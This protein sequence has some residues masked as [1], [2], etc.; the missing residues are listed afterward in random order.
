MS[1]SSPAPRSATLLDLLDRRVTDSPDALL[2]RFLEDEAEPTLSYA[3]LSRHARRIAAALQS[4]ASAGER[5]VLLYPPGLEYIAGFFGCLHAGLVAVPAYPPDPSRLERT[6]P[7]L[8]A[9]IRDAQATVVLTTSFIHSMGDFLFE[10]APDLKDL[11]WVATDA[12]PEDAADSW[13]RPELTADSLAFLQYTSGSTGTPKGVMLTH[14]NLLD[15][16]GHIHRSFGAHDDSVG[17]IWL[18][19]YHDMGLI[20]GILEPLYGGF[21]VA[22]L[23]PL[24]FLK[25]PL[26]WLEAVSRFGG[27]ISGG[28]NFAFELCT[29]KISPEQRQQLDLSRWELAFCGAE[30]IRPETLE[31]FVE[32][33]GPSGFRREALYPCY[34]LAEGTLIV[35]GA[36]KGEGPAL[37]AVKSEP[38]G[39][40]LVEP[41]RAGEQDARVLVGCGETMKEH[42]VLIVEPESLRACEAGQVG[43][44]WV[45]GPSVARGY[46][47][48]PEETARAFHATTADGDGP[49]LRTGD[50]GFLRGAELFVTGRLKDLLILRGR[51][52]YP[53]DLELTAE[54]AHPALRPGCG[55]AFGVEVEGEERLV[56]VQEVDPRRQLTSVDEVLAAVRQGLAESHEVQLHALVL[57]EPGSIPKTSSGKIQRQGTR[58]AWLAG[59]LREVLA[60]RETETAPSSDVP[61]A[62]GEETLDTAEALETWLRRRLAARAGVRLEAVAADEPITRYGLDSLGAA[63]LAHDAERALGVALSMDA[64]LR[65]PT[66]RALARELLE[67]RTGATKSPP[68]LRG[69]DV[70]AAP[71]SFTQQ[72]LWFLQQLEPSSPVYNIPAALR[73]EGALDV[74][75]LRRCFDLLVERHEALRTRVTHVEGQPVQVIAPARAVELPV[76]DLRDLP[77]TRREEE[78]LR[79]ALAQARR[80]FDLET[81]PLMRVVLLRLAEHTHVLALTLHHLVADGTSMGVL[82]RELAALYEALASGRASPLP[83]L[84]VRYVDYARWQRQWLNGE[85]QT[86]QVEYWRQRLA[87]AP[88]ALELP[89][90]K[91][92]PSVSSFH[93]A[94]VPV[95]LSRELT[96]A[97]RSLARDEGGTPFMVLLAGFQALLHRYSGQ[98]DLCVGTAIA[99]RHRAE[100]QGLVGPFINNLVLRT[101]LSGALTFRELIGR[102]REVTLGAYAHQDVPFEKLVEELRPRRDLGRAPFFQVMLLL[103]QDPLPAATMPGLSLRSLDVESPAAKYDLTLS[104]TDTADGLSGTLEYSTD[105]FEAGTVERMVTHLIA[106][107]SSAVAEPGQRV[108]ALGLLSSAEERRVTVEWNATAANFDQRAT[109]TQL[110]SAQAARTPEAV[111]LVCG[112]VSVTYQELRTRASALAHRLRSLG[113]GPGSLV[114]VCAS[115]SVELVTGLLGVLEAGGAYVPLDPSYPAERLA[116]MLRDCGARVLLTQRHLAGN[117]AAGSTQCVFLDEPSTAVAEVSSSG[118]ALPEGLAYVLYTSGST[119]TPKGVMVQH[120]NVA[121]FF[122]G[123]DARLGAAASGTWLAVTSV[124]FDISVLELLWTLCRGF[125]VVV[126]TEAEQGQVAEALLRHGATH[127]QLTPS[128]AQALLTETRG[129]EA[130][131]SVRRLLVGGEA[132][133]PELATRLRGALRGGVLLNMYG[134]TETTIWSSTHTVGDVTGSISIGTPIANTAL[135][136]LDARLRPVPVGVAGELYIGGEGVARGYLDRPALTAE[137]FV[138]DAYSATPG[139]RMYRTGDL[140]RWHADGTVEFLGRVDQQV[141]VRGYRIELGEVE[142]ALAQHPSVSV[143][144]VAARREQQGDT[145]LVAY[146]VPSGANVDFSA[147]RASLRQRLPEYMV[148]SAFMALDA[149]P[150]TPNGKVDR[151]A[152]PALD[153][154]RSEPGTEY[155]A[156]R[157]STEEALARVWSELLGVE[158]VGALDDFFELGGH[159]LLATQVIARVRTLFATELPLRELFEARTVA[160]L[161][162]RIEAARQDRREDRPYAPMRGLPR[163]DTLPLSFAQQR[164][165]VLDR[166]EPDSPLYNMPAVL[167]L[168]GTLDVSALEKTFDAAIRR[169]EG[170][171]ATFHTAQGTTVQRIASD[172]VLALPVVDV[173]TVPQAT[174]EAEV[175]RRILAEVKRPFDLSRAPLMRVLLLKL[176]EQEHVL[177][178]TMHHIISDGWSMDILVREMAALYEAITAGRPSP[179]PELKLQYADFAAW[180]RQWLE[181]EVLQNQLGWWRQ[182][183]DGIPQ[184]LQLPTDKPRPTARTYRGA[185][186][187][188]TLPTQLAASLRELSQREG[189]T[190]YMTLLAAFDVLLSRYSGQTDIVVGTDIANRT[191]AETEG[192]VGFFINQLVMRTRLDGDPTFRELLARVRE[193]SLGAYAHQDVPF[194][195]LVREL[196]PE[197]SL[198]HA[199]LFQ[200]KLVLQNLPQPRLELPGLSME[201]LPVDDHT[202]KFD[203]TVEFT[204]LPHGL[205]FLCEY[206]TD[207]FEAETIERMMGHLRT[208]LESA[209]AAPSQRL[210]QLPMLTPSERQL[211]LVD[212]NSTS[213]Q[214]LDSNAHLLFEAQVART[215][216]APAVSFESS[217]LTYLQLN[218]RSNQL[219]RH[220]RSLGVGPDTLVGLCVERSLDMVV[221]ILAV[222][223]AGGAYL[224]LDPSYP[225]QRLAFMLQ[226]ARPPVLL[227]QSHLADELP[228]QGEMLF[229]LDSDWPQVASLPDGDLSPLALADH[230]AYVIFTSGSTGQPKG[231]LLTH[232]GLC[233][234]ALAA[235]GALRLEPGQKALQFAAFGFDASVW[236][237]FS[238]LLS[239]AQLCLAPRDSLMPGLPLH[240]LLRQQSITTATLTPSVLAQTSHEGLESL[241]TLASAGEALPPELA[242]RWGHGRL[243]LNAYGPTEVTVC[244]SVTPGPVRPESLTIG[245]AL[246]NVRLFVLDSALH[247]VPLGVPGELFVGGPGLARGYLH[248]ADLSAERFIPDPFSSTPGARLYRTGDRVRWLASGE[249]DFLGR[250]DSQVKLRGFRIELGEVEAVLSL[251][252]SIH[253]A[254]ALVREDVPGDVR[255]VAYAV[256]SQGHELDSSALRAHLLQR[257][258]EYMVPSAFVSLAALPLT[259]NGKL[260][261]NALPAPDR[262]GAELNAEDSAALGETE[263]GIAS[264][265]ADLLNLERV[266]RNDSFFELGGH[267]LLATQAVSRIYETFGIELSLRDIFEAPTVAGLAS[268]VVE[269]SA[270]AR[271]NPAEQQIADI[272]EDLLK[273]ERVGLDDS[274]FELGGHSLL[275]TQAV[276]RIYETFGV[277][278]PLRDIFE[279][280]TV[281]LLAALVAKQ[282]GLV[283]PEQPAEE[284][285]EPAAPRIPPVSRTEALPLSFSQQRLWF[286]DQLEPGSATYNIPAVV[287]M[288]G[289]LHLAAL[290]RSFNALVQRHESL[291]TTLHEEASGPVQVIAS[292]LAV[293]LT[294][295]EL[296]HL[297]ESERHE[298]ML[299][300]A[301]EEASRPFDLTRGPL[302]RTTLLRLGEREHVLLLNMHHVVSDGWSLGVLIREMATLY[303]GFLSGRDVELPALPIQYA[304][305]ASWQRGWLQGEMLETQLDYWRQQLAGAPESLE[306]PTDKPRP[307]VQ[308]FRG[309]QQPVALS[310]ELSEALKALAR[311]EGVTPFMALLGAWQVLLSRYSGQDDFSIG[312][313]IAGRTRGETEGLIGF[314]VNTLVLRTK[315]DGNLSV[316]ELLARVK[317]TTL[318]AYAHQ[319]VPFEKLVDALQPERSLSRTPLFQVMFILQNA[320]VPE[321][322][323]PG[324][325]LKPVPVESHTSRFDLTLTLEDTKEG[326][327]GTLDY[328]TDL[329]EASTVAR[330]AGHLRRLIEGMVADPRRLTS[331][332]PML[333][334]AERHQ[335]LEGWNDTAYDY[336]REACIHDVFAQ[337]VALRPD[338]IALESSSQRLTY[339]QLDARAN[340]LAHLLQRHGVGPDSRVALCLER[341]VELVVSLLAILKAGGCYVP[342]DVDYPRERLAHMLE[343]AQPQVLVTTRA[344]AS[345]LPTDGLTLLLLDEVSESLA[346]QPTS[347]PVSATTSR[348]LVYID[349]TSG[350]TGRPKGVCIEHR[351]VMRLLMGRVDYMELGPQHSFLL[352]APISFDAS[353]LEVWGPLLHGGRL[354]LFPP[355]APNDVRELE[356]VLQTH[357]VTTL[358]LT[359]G[360]FTQMVD[361]HLEGLRTVKQL[362][363]GGD[364]VSAPHVRRVLEEL[365]I[366]V[367]ACY[368]PTESTL[369]AS[370]HRMTD[371]TQVGTSVP[372]GT[373]IGNTRLYVLDARLQP[374]PVGVPGELFISGDGLAR[375]YLGRPELTAERFLRDPFSP[376]PGARM[377]RTGDLVR[378]RADGVLE[379]LGRADTQV[380]IRGFRIELPEV[381]AALLKHPALHQAIVVAREDQ[382][383]KRLV[384]YVVGETNGAELR[385]HLKERLPEYMIPGAFV[386]LESLPLTANG[387][388]DRKALPAPDSQQAEMSSA[389]EAPR[390]A[391][392]QTLV[393]VWS[394]VLGRAQV[395]IR[396]NF[397]ELGGDSIV[398]LQVVARA[399]QAG[400]RLSP[401]QLFQHQTVEALAAVVSQAPSDVGEQGLVRGPV[402]L[403]PVQHAFFESSPLPNP[404]N[405]ALLLQVLSPLDT[406]VLEGA[407]RRLVEH[408]D[409]LRMKYSPRAEGDWSQEVSGLESPLNLV[410]VD[411]SAVPEAQQAQ[412]LE[413]EATRLQASLSLE[414]GLLLRAA[415]FSL[416]AGGPARLLLVAHHLVVDTVSWRVL[417][418]DL[419]SLCTQARAGQPLALPAKST[420]FKAWAEKL[421][422]YAHSEAL[423]RELGYWLNDA[424]AQVR[425]QPV[426]RAGGPNTFAS[427]RTLSLSL[428]AAETRTLLQE[429]PAAYRARIEDVLL[430]AL[431]HA[432]HQWTGHGSVLVEL[433]GHGRE[434]LFEGVDLSRTV[435]WFTTTYPAL[436]TLPASAS[437]GDVLRTVRDELR[438]L[439]SKGLGY[440]VLRHLTTGETAARLRDLPRAQ[441]SFNYLGQIDAAGSTTFALA[442]EPVG[443]SVSPDHERSH[444]LEVGGLIRGGE[445]HLS[446]TYSTHLHERATV[447]ALAQGMLSRLRAL[448]SGR[449]TEDARRFTPADFPLAALERD[450]LDRLLQRLG[451]DV[452][453]LYPLSPMQQGMLFHALLVPDSSVY[454]VQS[455]FRIQGHFDPKRF[456]RAWDH[457]VAR[458]PILRTRFVWEGLTEPLQ[459]VHARAALPWHQL[460]WRHLD[461][462]E[463]RAH[464]DTFLAED[465]AR[466]FDLASPPLMRLAVLRLGDDSW[467]L[468]WSQH[469]LLLDGWSVGQLL[470]DLFATYDALLRSEQPRLQPRPLYRDYIAWLRDSS[471]PSAESYWREELQGFRSPTPLP[472]ASSSAGVDGARAMGKRALALSS[473][474]SSALQDFARRHQLTLNTLLQASWAL[475]LSRY[476]GD[477]DVLFGATSAARPA[478]LPSSQAMMGLFINSLPVRVRVEARQPVLT[479][480]RQLQERQSAQAA[481]EH[482]P[483]VQVQSWSQLPRGAA[484]FDS[485]LVFENYPLEASLR[486]RTGDFEVLD[487]Q[488]F[489]HTNYPLTAIVSPGRQLTLT[490]S[491][492]ASRFSP[493]AIDRLLG[494]WQVLLEGLMGHASLRLDEVPMLTAS[495]RQQV[496]VDWNATALEFPR[497]E[498]IH[499]LFEAQAQRTPDAPAVF[500]EG[501]QLSYRQL[502]ERANQLAHYLRTLGVGPEVRVA[503]CAERSLEMVIALFAILKAGGAYVPLDPAYPRER[504]AFMLEDC[505][506]PVLLTQQRLASS[507][508]AHSAAVVLLDGDVSVIARQPITPPVSGITAEHLAYVIYTSG[509]TGRPKGAMNPH[510]GVV[511]RLRWMPRALGLDGSDTVLQKTPFSFDVSVWEF[512]APLMVGARLVVARPGGHQ[513]GAYLARLIAQQRIT[514]L[515]FVPSMLQVFLEQPRLDETCASVKQVICSGEAL[516]AVLQQRFHQQFPQATLHNLYGPTEAAVEVT[517][518]TCPRGP[519]PSSVPI[520]RP[521]ANTRAYVLDEALHPVPPGVAGELY[522]AGIQVG[523]GYWR[524]PEL[525]AE[526]FIPNP[527]STTPGERLYRTG[528]KVR[529]REDGA[530]DYLGRFDF[531]V[532]VRGFRIELGEIEAILAQQ[533]GLKDAV[534]V[535]REDVPGD[536][537]LVAYVVMHPGHTLDTATLSQAL[538]QH[539]PEHMVPSAF[540][541]LDTLPLSPNGKLDRRALPAPEL[542]A[543]VLAE[544]VAPRTPTEQLIAG[545]FAQVLRLERVGATSDFFE[546]G[547]HSLL[548]TQV[549]SRLRE[550]FGAEVSLRAIFEAPTVEALSLRVDATSGA[551]VQAPAMVPA[552]RTGELPL[553]FAQQRLWFLHQLE[554]AS[555]LYNIPTAL[556][557]LG[558]LDVAALEKSFRDII[559]RHEALRTTFQATAEE[560]VQIISASLDV[561]LIRA[562]LRGLTAE[563]REAEL[564][565]RVGE[566]A[567]HAFDLARGPLFRITLLAMAEQ[568]HVLLLTMHHTIADGWSLDVLIREMAALYEAFTSGRSSTLPELALQYVDYAVWQRGWLRGEALETQLSFWRQQLA[569]APHALELLTDKVRPSRQTHQGASLPLTLSRELSESL[570]QLAQ[571]EGV[572]PFMVLLAT[573]QLLL[574]RYSGQD[575]ITIGSPIAGRN[576]AETEELIGN[577]VNTLVLRT[578]LDGNPT[579]RELLGRV[580]E[581]ALGAYAHQDVPFERL[582]EE[583]RP[584]RDL[585]RPPLFQAM[586]V[587]HN[588]PKQD[589]SFAGLSLHRI[590]TEVRTA[591]MELSLSLEDTPR[592]FTGSLDYS[593]DLFEAETIERMMGHLRTLLESAVAAPTQRL[594]Q[595]PM[596]TPSERQLLLVDWNSTSLQRL[597]S[598]AHLLFEAQVART[599]HAPAV[600]FESSSLTYLQ[601]NS[602]SNQLARHLRS[603]GVGPDT[604]VGLCVERSLDMVVA[605]LAVLK[606]GGAY[607]PLDPSYPAQRLAFMLQQARPPVLLTQSHLADELPSQGEMLFCL[608]SDWPQVASLPDG[609]LSPLALADHLAYVIFTSGSTGQPKGTLLTHRGLCNTALAAASALRLEPGQKALQFAAF[610]FDAS[611]WECFSALL[612][613]AQLCL[614]PRD[615]LMPGLPLH[616][617]LRQQSITTATLTPSV[618]AQTSH[619]GLESLRTLAS[620]GEALPAE[621]ARRWGHGRLLLNAYG[622][623]EVTVCASVTPG[624]VRPESLTIGRALP[625][626]RLF[627]LDSALHPVPL[628]VPG[629]LFVGGPG[630]ARGYLHRAD[631]SAERFIPDPFSSSPGARLYRTGDRVRWLASG[632][633]DFLGRADSQVKLRG[634]RIELGEVE[635]V[636]SL[637]PSIHEAVALVRED[638][639][640][641][642]RLVAYA[643]LSQGHE[644]D[645]AA[646]RAHLLQRLPEYMVP[647]AFVSLAAL[648]LTSNGKLDRN[649]LPAPELLRAKEKPFIAP[650]TPMEEIITAI[651]RELVAVDA[652]STDD[653]FFDLGG[654][655]LLATQ[656]ISRIRNAFQVEVPLSDLFELRTVAEL[657]ARVEAAARAAHRV[658]APPLQPRASGGSIPLS[659]AQHRLL[660]LNKLEPDSPLYNMAVVLRLE[661]ALDASALEKSFNELIRRHEGL[662][663]TFHEEQG[664]MV[665]HITPELTL[666]LPVVDLSGVSPTELEAEVER[667][668]LEEAKRPFDLARAPLMRV[669][670]LRLAERSHVLLLTMHHI[671]SDGWSM[672]ILVREVATGYQ[673]LSTGQPSPLSDLPVQYADYAAWQRQWLEGE[674][675]QGQL[676]WWRQQL[677]GIPQLLQLPTDKPRPT[678]R[679]V[680]GENYRFSLSPELVTAMKTLSQREGV[681]LYMTLMAAFD[682]LL[683]RYS[684]QTDIVVGTDIA[685]R[686][687]AE[688]EGLIGFFINQLVMRTRL[689]GDPTFRELLAR[690]R[691][692][693][694]GAYAHQDVPFEELVRELNPER[695]LGHA[696][697]FQVKLVLQNQPRSKLDLPDLSME[698]VPVDHHT[699]KFDLTLSFNDTGH[700]LA[701]FCE[702]STDLF[703]AETIE[704]MMGHLRTL[705]ESAVA[706]PTQRLSQL[707]MLTPSER[708]LLLVDWSS[709]ALQRQDSNAHLLFEAQV[710]RTPHAPAVSFESSSLTY[711]QLNS[712]S[713]QLARHL[714]SL[715]VGPDTLVGLCVE[716]SLDMVVAILAVLKAGG[717]Y[718]PLDPSYPAQRLAFMLQQARPPVLLTQSHLADELPS[719]GEMLFCLDSDWPQVASLP[720]GDLSPLALA[721]HLAYVIFTSGSTGQPKGTLLTHRGLCNTALAAAGALRLE[722]GQKALQFAAFGFDASVWECFSALLSGAQLCL[723]PR[724]SLTPGLP[725]HALLRQQSITTATLTP[726]VLAQ[727]SHEGLESLRT[728]ASAGEAL[729]AELARRW[730]Q[731]RLLL[732]AY[733]P[734]EVTVCASVTPG[735][736]RPESLTIGRALPNVRLFVL[737][738]ALHPVP[739]GVPGELFV[740]GPGLAR[741]YLHR[742]DLSAERFIPDP[743]SSSPGARLYRTGD[744]VRWLASGELDFLGRADSQVKLRGFRIELGEVEAVLSLHPSIHEAIALVRED[745]PGDVRLVAYAVLSQGHELDSA[746]L[747]AHLLQRLPEYMVPSAFVSLAT[748]PLTSNGKLDRN[749]LP[750][751]DRARMDQG[752]DFEPPQGEIE[753]QLGAIF[754]ELL[755][756]TQVGRNDSFF[757]LGGHSLLA[758]QAISRV[759]E[760]FGVQLPLREIFETPTIANLSTHIEA[761]LASQV[762]AEELSRMMAELEEKP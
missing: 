42:Q 301:R 242:R 616:A 549:V 68:L 292:T 161:A 114:A 400:L 175:E 582:V 247:P 234:T 577:F 489:D 140:A 204:D 392:E 487:V 179:L 220:L 587:L 101:Q 637:H 321:L 562:D 182:Q 717:A 107:L 198:G 49:F 461:A 423:T 733:G 421:Q 79:H 532:K 702:Y 491:Y 119:G 357:A 459:V 576:R 219:A 476:S 641:D 328:S 253:E 169:H 268:H 250:A 312:S 653:D 760:L 668:S 323:L 153:P 176:A 471:R 271:R 531:Q 477:T 232:R 3:G 752:L 419:E 667:L 518:W 559:R 283:I 539:L 269:K 41:A 755:G 343:D 566:E 382:G 95:R 526:R 604:L 318:G 120:R 144:V 302:L 162:S 622:P 642:V 666:P 449:T 754:M 259:S 684:G 190:L 694:L 94:S 86:S 691:E 260:D 324:L 569:G 54:R 241:R 379:F 180:Q 445:L 628:G 245:R 296:T 67:A 373:P 541:A 748:L 585:S 206:S 494:H 367:T 214:R 561:P 644:L 156:P 291:R 510:A 580:R 554:P 66:P 57:I 660:F 574:S 438:R 374:V 677:D 304:D 546:L 534:V 352:I 725:L 721:D 33:F 64:L 709:T 443:T 205:D 285:T 201:L 251:H 529:W 184:L 698:M 256:L 701:A 552:P 342:L 596:L 191:H 712:R 249:L 189:V 514:L 332:L 31:R 15:N 298:Q 600:S 467:Q 92:R 157:T 714:R 274:F 362:L 170:L 708:Q 186:R 105:L 52:H 705:L 213:L 28:P 319:D 498:C 195:E 200:V 378:R 415:H 490:F 719:Q 327:R 194:E 265:F 711:L 571:R 599:P 743:F 383:R 266:G 506:A 192:L 320:P 21:P 222:L 207:L 218:S 581:S 99:G 696:P 159:S 329:F 257:L 7:R 227:T 62:A 337:Q 662:R 171:R 96:Q 132:L 37:H 463:Q 236:E 289:A 695:S 455:S 595:L 432:V 50:L 565:H 212:W 375:G 110:F 417:I 168:H 202:S 85:V 573:W 605:I 187:V 437:P 751:P 117:I 181:G 618:L 90:D 297:P 365:R 678:S 511:N 734:T 615:S 115:R 356:A 310:S 686:T 183:L 676:G 407:L 614:A 273:V 460:D 124:S 656:V 118:G 545:M 710:A 350:S 558:A 340:Q 152:L 34:G 138:P 360:L 185:T 547:G 196:N 493:E 643:V 427:S 659:F 137:R 408:H 215:P 663:A 74:G 20:G 442:N 633:L 474:S 399:R 349:F 610:G 199:P 495:E 570:H 567:H 174:R 145:R 77:E 434:D 133:P 440:G 738:S 116:F 509:S 22:L 279:A 740:G 669:T 84:P 112:D 543:T 48:R 295:V 317:E 326:F 672:S 363:T 100:L 639:P 735:Q 330:M 713:N 479:W 275:A 759:D 613:G 640:G 500:F 609:D 680:R 396:D 106:L 216:H 210:S 723:A 131:A 243:L 732:N 128:R 300:L 632:E 113:V 560:P 4:I 410:R 578:K 8:R 75:L 697:L 431:T 527:F 715:G 412:A 230:L 607:L 635:A 551:G 315:L 228:S 244:A 235:A 406:T 411:L 225:A 601:L 284:T 5:A 252:P 535:V 598:N 167:R 44:V 525:T 308:S 563:A 130:L 625:N 233:N 575:D 556:R 631:L 264:I 345:R 397:F 87:G 468:V 13:K 689:D 550:A 395:G 624:P 390:N 398:S 178:L 23:S 655:S 496:L 197:R 649:A 305:Y 155:V 335:V 146:V 246:P 272:F 436:F 429:V 135:Y 127:L 322:A 650:R 280:P 638:V 93:G 358:H 26:R 761:A 583:L 433:E 470:Q 38:L 43:E 393:D 72:R 223:K 485:L 469:H 486:Q 512:F 538:K 741:G 149:L 673:A 706:A 371:T 229:C 762:D 401:R 501:Q 671:I 524:R 548:A 314:F 533:P 682:V 592:G 645:S 661:G 313:P 483:L 254:V 40:N 370:C 389:Y 665:Q 61:S 123:M 473:A 287:R 263:E 603:L 418:E 499:H 623:T 347:T 240:A 299:R 35:S 309:A 516:P 89:T 685:N 172:V 447:E 121:N 704:R 143:A 56:L 277:E 98:E 749:A 80:S 30:P 377:Y 51:N 348:N 55:A 703:E 679:T 611:V 722:P 727:T 458:N 456:Q 507:L 528:D 27:T 12:L 83:E 208:L 589:V 753:T 692:A 658:Q 647:S 690:V 758:T 726:S 311:R 255:L 154:G 425:P 739:L 744:R 439:P 288:E 237:C 430:G 747:R 6:L 147:L 426:D 519:L 217:S 63:E 231:T 584:E 530:I 261:R 150:L 504:L 386:R 351:S 316:R 364:V 160:A 384:A 258:P 385:A 700:G 294:A 14:A 502:D 503:L 325:T 17:V 282:A 619:E 627:V 731:G 508:P 651:W 750:A 688:T 238:A 413:A 513:D 334:E 537:R 756:L 730:G 657:S 278:L 129:Q 729:P 424:R 29:R 69:D 70:G 707:P 472:G 226:Q 71:L 612:S 579:F 544:Y 457:V 451:P 505:G 586:F 361:A 355:H 372:I 353:T 81:G 446:F 270:E 568:E 102:V 306:L 78:A 428:D 621:L 453:D 158:R 718:L 515:H 540:V 239:G 46:W 465:R 522:L 209:V 103:Q 728:L 404:F 394:K 464:I 675:L 564:R 47:Q 88:H 746:A 2:Y 597:D 626:V 742:A 409:A 32:A 492:E 681:T 24:D 290:E 405:Q 391:T 674:V 736:V 454:F 724:D 76:V 177:V 338:A 634:F 136:I 572:T 376:E 590:A 422:Q 380:K 173:S 166:L 18:P 450:T 151:K 281:A 109:L 403:T 59:E 648:P 588:T 39:R 521:I 652:V 53:Q 91:P 25:R 366:P 82:V 16:L 480:L 134:P 594:S 720:D 488:A 248:R 664:S 354:V 126:H 65:G 267:S 683:S 368:G 523:R 336:P 10:H 344:L 203:V 381:E 608:D 333:S 462:Q 716:R 19:P 687:H 221:A 276:S 339:R 331:S 307:G 435:G 591:K 73:L 45:R 60:W 693:S 402:P 388:V 520:G 11:H 416:G 557:L 670:L 104:L 125:K 9:V 193:A 602:R 482:T 536:K 164:L 481:H 636:L 497:G 444:A 111:A 359:A 617:L 139:A 122:A 141:K 475:L 555:P 303:E 448:I 542:A 262:A 148:P 341:S 58:A 188:L 630:L 484:L 452:E 165:W 629:E 286:L 142:A 466:G 654:H 369:F 620:A 224:P 553:S 108:G 757:E 606:A 387:K 478:E 293:P 36:R 346:Q 163:T 699:S 737:D 646:L 745:V 517:A 97:L 420:S 211:L 441:L 414:E 1:S 593:T